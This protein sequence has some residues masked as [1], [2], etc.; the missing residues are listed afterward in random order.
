MIFAF[1]LI[2]LLLVAVFWHEWWREREAE[3]NRRERERQER[4]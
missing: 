3:R 1:G 4:P 2:I